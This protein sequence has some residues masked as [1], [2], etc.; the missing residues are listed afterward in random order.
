MPQSLVQNFLHIVFATKN[1][2][3]LISDEITHD[4]Y[5]YVGCICLTLDCHPV[6]T[7]GH[8][9]HVQI[10]SSLSKM[11]TVSKLPEQV[12]SGSSKWLRM[13]RGH[14]NFNWQSGYTAFSVSERHL[15][16]VKE[17]IAAQKRHHQRITFEDELRTLLTENA[18]VFDKDYPMGL[19]RG[20][21][22]SVGC[23][24]TCRITGSDAGQVYSSL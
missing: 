8:L 21:L 24:F 3:P 17:Y 1:R 11:M 2:K 18:I 20:V 23:I 12:K 4:L 9:N 14:Q 6:I 13:Q 5:R 7:G 10:P 16:I 19:I 15:H 22:L